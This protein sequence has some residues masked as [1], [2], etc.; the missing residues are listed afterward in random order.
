MTHDEMENFLRKQRTPFQLEELSDKLVVLGT[1]QHGSVGHGQAGSEDVREAKKLITSLNKAFPSYKWDVSVEEEWVSIEGRYSAKG[2]IG[3][4]SASELFRLI[5]RN[6][7]ST[8]LGGEAGIRSNAPEITIEGVTFKFTPVTW[9]GPYWRVEV[10]DGYANFAAK[11]KK[12]LFEG[13]DRLLR[14]LRKAH[15]QV[16]QR[17]LKSYLGYK[18]QMLDPD[19]K[20]KVV[21]QGKAS[22]L[23]RDNDYDQAL[24]EV[25]ED[26]SRKR[27][28][29]TVRAGGGAGAA[30]L[31]KKVS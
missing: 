26:L 15:V 30:W 11:T 18:V 19:F 27:R 12:D 22:E 24:E 6:Y 10:R 17:Y 4:L 8:T 5:K 21:W 20:N 9:Q 13:L 29:E 3:N 1:R 28:G 31:L 14:K 2:G 16:A 23:L 25:L 7:P